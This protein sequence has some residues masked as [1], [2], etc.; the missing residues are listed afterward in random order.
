MTE[1]PG[2]GHDSADH[3]DLGCMNGWGYPIQ[4]GP[5]LTEGCNCTIR[6]W[7]A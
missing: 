7:V 4:G 5:A 2:C 1:C 6:G 3:G